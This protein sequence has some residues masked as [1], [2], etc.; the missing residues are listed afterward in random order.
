MIRPENERLAEQT[1]QMIDNFQQVLGKIADA[2]RMGE[3]MTASA[4]AEYGRITVT[5]DASGSIVRTEF[6]DDVSD[7][8]YGAIA[9]GILQ[10]AQQAA[11]EVRRKHEELTAPLQALRSG[12]PGIEEGMARLAGLRDQ[13]PAP[14]PAP[15]TSPS[16]RE[17]YSGP[18]YGDG[19]APR[20]EP[21]HGILDR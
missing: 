7:L 3:A 5:V 15:L 14:V 19:M 12:M 9:R 20:H 13:V 16:E 6:S 2:R 10:A 1:N 4:A 21:D 11:A 17:Q 18:E 8:G